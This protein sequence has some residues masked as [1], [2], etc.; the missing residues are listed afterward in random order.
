MHS[1][2]AG[3]GGRIANYLVPYSAYMVTMS[4]DSTN[5]ALI[6]AMSIDRAGKSNCCANCGVK[7]T[8][9]IKLMICT[10]CKSVH[11]CGVECQKKHR[12]K[13][14]KDCKKRA[15]ELRDE[16]LF[17]QPESTHMGDCPIC[18]L[19]HPL[20]GIANGKELFSCCSQ[21]VCMG[22]THANTMREIKLKQA[23]RCPFCRSPCGKNKKQHMKYIM[24]RA[25]VNC[26]VALYQLGADA[27]T[28][29]KYT[30]AMKYLKK[31]VEL[32]NM[33]SN[34]QI[35]ELYATGSGGEKDEKK[36]ITHLET[37]AIG[38]HPGA[39]FYLASIEMKNHRPDRA[40]KHIVIAAKLG[41]EAGIKQLQCFYEQ[42]MLKKEVFAEALR[43]YQSAENATKSPHREE[44]EKFSRMKSA[45]SRMKS[46]QG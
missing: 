36:R 34:Y 20:G 14:E 8:K 9:D 26:P 29:G 39:R 40:I 28:G 44:A 37:A 22:C 17:K 21:L 19:P 11:Y 15:A 24:E 42:G 32:G 1:S 7:E 6:G 3:A 27:H 35:A 12:P 41:E 23:Q 5:N 2:T 4:S 30:D 18:C 46:E 10:A 45:F 43:G 38:G 13:H 31:A 16:I 33:D 25:A